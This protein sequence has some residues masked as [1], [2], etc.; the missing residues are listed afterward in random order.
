[1]FLSQFALIFLSLFSRD[2]R[3]CSSFN[4]NAFYLVCDPP[5]SWFDPFCFSPHRSVLSIPS[6]LGNAPSRRLRVSS[7]GLYFDNYCTFECD[8]GSPVA[9]FVC[10]PQSFLYSLFYCIFPPR[11][12][13]FCVPSIMF[14]PGY[15]TSPC[16]RSWIHA[17]P[18]LSRVY[19][20]VAPQIL[21]THLPVL[22]LLSAALL[23]SVLPAPPLL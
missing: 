13:P 4:P 19:F 6:L 21:S 18:F 9:N 2:Y 20:S 15:S 7:T 10:P 22:P 3:N 16:F 5:A 23:L 11:E 8:C 14:L 17:L 1:M 12:S